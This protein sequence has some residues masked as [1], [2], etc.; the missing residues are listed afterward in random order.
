MKD[1]FLHCTAMGNGAQ[2]LQ[3]LLQTEQKIDT[4]NMY[5]RTPLSW[6]AEYGLERRVNID[7]INFE[8]GTPL[9]GANLHAQGWPAGDGD[10]L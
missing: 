9:A 5:G 10:S 7:T 2:L 3:Y 6:A 4:R 1:L 8:V